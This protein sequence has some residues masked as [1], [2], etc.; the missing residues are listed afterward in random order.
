MVFERKVQPSDES[1]FVRNCLTRILVPAPFEV[2]SERRIHYNDSLSTNVKLQRIAEEQFA[3][4][5]L[6]FMLITALLK[7]SANIVLAIA[8]HLSRSI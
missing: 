4:I 8:R 5:G 3:V 2:L 6:T 7:C 1:A